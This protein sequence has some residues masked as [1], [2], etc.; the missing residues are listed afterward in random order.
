MSRIDWTAIKQ[1]VNN[2]TLLF[3]LDRHWQ[4]LLLS[5]CENYKWEA[6]YRVPGYDYADWDTLQGVVEQG[7]FDLM[8]GVMLSDILG[9]I[10]DIETLLAEIRDRPCCQVIDNISYDPPGD[11]P[12]T[13]S[14]IVPGVGDPPTA[15]GD[16]DTLT[17]WEDWNDYVCEAAYF[18][19]A[20]LSEKLRDLAYLQSL[21]G[22]INAQML[23]NF[24][25]RIPALGSMLKSAFEVFASL[26]ELAW[27]TLTDLE[28][29]A[30]QIDAAADDIACAIVSADG[31]EAA[32]DAFREAAQEAVTGL[33]ASALVQFMLYEQWANIIYTGS[34]VDADDVSHDLSAYLTPG[35]HVCCPPIVYDFDYTYEFE[36]TSQ[37]MGLN[38]AV[39]TSDR[40]GSIKCDPSWQGWTY[41]DCSEGN[42]LGVLGLPTNT[43]L[44]TALVVL[45][46]ERYTGTPNGTPDI[47]MVV[48]GETANQSSIV[49]YNSLASGTELQITLEPTANDAK[50]C[51]TGSSTG[52]YS[53]RLTRDGDPNPGMWLKSLRLA[54]WVNP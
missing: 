13:G 7:T 39:W 1:R 37:G 2:D 43:Y 46:L 22:P 52:F 8:G 6:T 25:G 54:G 11:V 4:Q 24:L 31:V 5:V 30:D 51:Q 50:Y 10:D 15:Y 34:V 18:F 36:T 20:V 21:P 3:V 35:T 17:T 49:E 27:V 19:V 26:M 47:Q 16:D 44:L 48:Y 40:G 23:A 41:I 14:P 33:A 45:T 53:T 32:A 12:N 9:Y 42:I 29:A 38:K 28:T